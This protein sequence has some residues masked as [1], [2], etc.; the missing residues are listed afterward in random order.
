MK[1]A[2]PANHCGRCGAVAYKPELARDAMTRPIRIAASDLT[3]TLFD[4]SESA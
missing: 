1:D 3:G 2:I 4:E